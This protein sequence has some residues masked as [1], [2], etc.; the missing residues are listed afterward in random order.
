MP[1]R[2]WGMPRRREPAMS[3]LA[4]ARF[5]ERDEVVRAEQAA[6]DPATPAR[7]VDYAELRK[8]FMER[9]SETLAY[10]AK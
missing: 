2:S 4:Y 6:R 1:L 7:Q 5:E 10:L 3:M 8:R 9:F